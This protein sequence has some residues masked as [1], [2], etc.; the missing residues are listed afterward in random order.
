MYRQLTFRMAAT[1][2]ALRSALVE[3]VFVSVSLCV[4]HCVVFLWRSRSAVVKFGENPRERERP[5]FQGS[6][7]NVKTEILG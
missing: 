4:C 1:R 3:D 6:C 2:R 7:F 5:W